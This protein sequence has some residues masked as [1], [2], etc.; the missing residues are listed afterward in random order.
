MMEYLLL[1]CG[2]RINFLLPEMEDNNHHVMIW[3]QLLL[4]VASQ[5]T[6]TA[7]LLMTPGLKFPE[8]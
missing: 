6:I 2:N 3:Q 1:L 8:F 4:L 5:G 7:S